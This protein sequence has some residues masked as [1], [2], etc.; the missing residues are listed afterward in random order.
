MNPW[1]NPLDKNKLQEKLR[2]NKETNQQI[3]RDFFFPIAKIRTFNFMKNK[4]EVWIKMIRLKKN[5]PTSKIQS[6]R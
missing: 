4:L 6:R 1:T 3:Q 5:I 2:M